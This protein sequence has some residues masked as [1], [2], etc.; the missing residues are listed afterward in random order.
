MRVKFLVKEFYNEMFPAWAS[1]S[2]RPPRIQRNKYSILFLLHTTSQLIFDVIIVINSMKVSR[3]L[4]D[5]RVLW[6]IEVDERL[7]HFH[8]IIVVPDT[9]PGVCAKTNTWKHTL[10]RPAHVVTTVHL[11]AHGLWL[12]NN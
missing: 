7:N 3:K 6:M 1:R 11:I 4:V 12:C 2:T 10:I 8:S 9:T 5:S